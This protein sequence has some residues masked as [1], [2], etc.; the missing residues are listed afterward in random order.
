[1]DER[2][3]DVELPRAVAD[4]LDRGALVLTGNQRAA[5]TLQRAVDRRNSLTSLKVWQPAAVLAWDAW[6]AE[7]WRSL[8]LDGR[9][10]DMLLSAAQE[11]VIW[12]N[13][14]AS[15]PESQRHLRSVDSLAEL[16]A[17]GW[18]LLAQYNGLKRLHSTAISFEARTFQRWAAEFEKRCRN[19][20]WLSLAQLEDSL[21]VAISS[22]YLRLPGELALVGFYEMYPA[23]R[24][25]IDSIHA[26]GVGVEHV[27]TVIDC[28]NPLLVHADDEA[29]EIAAVARWTREQLRKSPSMRLAIVVPG[30]ET[31][32]SEINRTFR[33]IL[34]PELQDINAPTD[35]APYEF[36]VGVRL[37][38]TPLVRVALDILRWINRP[39]PIER[40][41]ALLVSPLVAYAETEGEARG[42]FDAFY[43][44]KSRLLRP[45]FTMDSI[46]EM[47]D[48]SDRKTYLRHLHDAL[49]AIARTTRKQSMSTGT[50]S[51]TDWADFM[52]YVLAAA[53]W[54]TSRTED[55]IEF[56]TRKRWEN[57]LDELAT[58]GFAGRLVQYADALHALERI[59]GQSMFAPES[60]EAP[61]Q[62]VGPLEVAGSTFDAL[63][64]MRAGD[65]TWPTKPASNPLLPWPLQLQL[66]M[67]GANPAT[68]D[69]YARIVAETIAHSAS[70][71]IFSY[72]RETEAGKQRSTPVLDN[73]GLHAV[74]IE[75][76]AAPD[77][78][79]E[80]LA[81]EEFFDITPI[82]SL[83]DRKIQGGA[84]ILRL[85]AACGFRAF[86]ERRLWSADLKNLELGMDAAE[87]GNIVH[88]ALEYLW[89]E[90]KTQAELRRMNAEERQTMLNRS[91]EYGLQHVLESTKAE[92]DAA[93]VEVQR[94]RLWNVLTPWLD[95]ELNREE[96]RVKLSEKN[97]DDVAIGPLRLSVRVDRV[98]TSEKGDILIDYKTGPAKPAD[99]QS[100]RPDAPQ[101]PLYAV[102]QPETQL[103][104]IAFARIR[105]GSD[106][107]LDGFTEKVTA[108]ETK[109]S[110]RRSSIE[111]QLDEW[112]VVLTNL[113]EAF[114]QGSA[115]VDPKNYPQTCTYCGQRT[116]CRLNPASFDEDID[117]E[118]AFD[119][120]NG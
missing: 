36:S 98:D 94:R 111:Q 84:E 96:F 64:F 82:P 4:A 26:S 38:E 109:S 5:R 55:S 120:G 31:A 114:D 21:Q 20:H 73:L 16:A 75:L 100:D 107:G 65:L 78:R 57:V 27:H 103:A 69:A 61:V 33:E 95:V 17:D 2:A 70:T 35:A 50:R 86:A 15:D 116:L 40:V 106:M 110:R 49:K 118:T 46:I 30:L 59:A 47:I 13:I 76:V 80:P 14:I 54:N 68:D 101:L 7:L 32:R 24:D 44:R 18:R 85:Q 90:V 87:R 10:D 93:Y 51:Y 66:G 25:L 115:T 72:A 56:Q 99:W 97:F 6:T 105:P 88:R 92:W 45:E 67:P 117:E 102:V 37:S 12:C 39:L 104:E 9:V 41:S 29:K 53:Q 71:A 8:L 79:Q 91:I 63:W 58:L 83:P 113:A 81:L 34:A 22:G 89:N 48:R 43:L 77:E 60:R 1:M 28:G 112:R 52:R 74:A 119:T 42:C 62:I 19:Q 23:R 11:H 108:K 3:F